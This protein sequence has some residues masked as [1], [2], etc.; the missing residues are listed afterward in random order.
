M[1]NEQKPK[2]DAYEEEISNHILSPPQSKAS[3]FLIPD[4]IDPDEF[5]RAYPSQ[6]WIVEDAR[7]RGESDE[8]ISTLLPHFLRQSPGVLEQKVRLDLGLPIIRVDSK[9]DVEGRSE[10]EKRI[11]RERGLG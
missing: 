5:V 11:R 9:G 7:S 3:D 1:S 6:A 8:S 4:Q 2:R 10:L